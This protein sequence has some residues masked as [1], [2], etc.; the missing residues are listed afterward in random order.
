MSGCLLLPLFNIPA[1]TE[2]SCFEVV[3]YCQQI[4]SLRLMDAS[5]LPPRPCLGWDLVILQF[6]H[7]SVT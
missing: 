3:G 1:A 2:R 6:S 4:S 5:L 7:S